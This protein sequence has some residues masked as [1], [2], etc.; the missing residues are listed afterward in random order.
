MHLSRRKV[1]FWLHAGIFSLYLGTLSVFGL[2]KR[3]NDALGNAA[4][5]G[6]LVLSLALLAYAA[7]RTRG[8]RCSVW[9]CW[10]CCPSCIT[11]CSW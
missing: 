9:C 10:D 8:C 3:V 4:L 5:F 1:D 6:L 2:A 11:G 7:L